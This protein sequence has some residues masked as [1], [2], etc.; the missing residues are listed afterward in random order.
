MSGFYSSIFFIYSFQYLKEEG[1]QFVKMALENKGRGKKQSGGI[2]YEED[3]N[4][5]PVEAKE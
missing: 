4:D 1:W 5:T 2:G 3:S